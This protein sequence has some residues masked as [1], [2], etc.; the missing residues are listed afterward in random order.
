MGKKYIAILLVF[1]MLLGLTA[2][3]TGNQAAEPTTAPTSAP[4]TT[5]APGEIAEEAAEPAIYTFAFEGMMGKETA[6]FEL[7]PDGTCQFSLPGNPMLKDD[8]GG[9]FSREGDTVTVEGLVNLDTTSSFTTPGLW[10]WIVDGGTVITVDDAAGTFVPVGGAGGSTAGAPGGE[11]GL[12]EGVTNVAYASVSAA[13]V[14]DIYTPE[15]IEKAPVIVLVHGGGF[16]FGD[17][18]MTIIKPVIKVAVAHGYAVVSV[19]YRKSAEAVF[20]G[21][22]ADV[23]AAVRFVRANAEEYG[24]DSEHITIWG[25][26]AGAYLSEMTALTPEVSE[27]NGDVTDNA[28]I[29]SA[30]KGLVTFY[31]PVE[32]WTMDEEYASLGITNSTF[33]TDSSFESKFLGQ[34][35]GAD[36]EKTYT[37][38][39]ET[40]ADRLPEN[41]N[42]LAWIQVGN[43]DAR[44]PYTQSEHFAARL[45]ERIGADNVHFDILDGADHEDDA[46]YTDEN[47]NAS[48]RGW[49]AL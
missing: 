34:N 42:L 33:A 31:A 5:E 19:D 40:Y 2:C 22:L 49:M 18:A 1:V 27:L 48:L 32:F 13:Q 23:K 20:P 46:F 41:F 44:V 14:C 36:R 11:N 4:I 43:A 16:A 35:I 10:D 9:T 30:V 25:E 8:Y 29:S 21:A 7:A 26:S 15:G 39:W 12:P 38:Y 24:L 6:Q 47:L 3:G 17:Q 37:T 28:G 45:A